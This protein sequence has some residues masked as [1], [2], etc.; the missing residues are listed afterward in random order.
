MQHLVQKMFL[1]ALVVTELCVV[2]GLWLWTRDAREQLAVQFEREAALVETKHNLEE[3]IRSQRAYRDAITQ[4]RD[5]LEY[6]VRDKL[7]YA[8][9]D[10]WIFVIPE[11]SPSVV[12]GLR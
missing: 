11:S 6:V 8:S 2:L 3:T 1:A 12:E 4:D 7:G 5:F 9:Q 10:E